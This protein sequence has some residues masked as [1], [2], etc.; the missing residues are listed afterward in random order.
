M[1]PA[2]VG[3]ETVALTGDIDEVAPPP[4]VAG[5]DIVGEFAP[6]G[7]EVVTGLRIDVAEPSL[8]E[9]FLGAEIA[10]GVVLGVL[11]G[12]APNCDNSSSTGTR[13]C[14]CTNFSRPNSR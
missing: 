9:V 3:F 1:E 13:R 7:T 12:L 4:H 5:A 6:D 11:P 14:T 8:R 2:V 10:E